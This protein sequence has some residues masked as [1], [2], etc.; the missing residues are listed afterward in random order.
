MRFSLEMSKVM[1]TVVKISFIVVLLLPSLSF[2]KNKGIQHADTQ[3]HH[4]IGAIRRAREQLEECGQRHSGVCFF[5]SWL[6]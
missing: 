1:S 6:W 5:W 4:I 3:K 2:A